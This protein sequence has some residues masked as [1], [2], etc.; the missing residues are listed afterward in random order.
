MFKPDKHVCNADVDRHLAS[1]MV[2]IVRRY[3]NG[4]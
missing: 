2:G 3:R 1:S 4:L